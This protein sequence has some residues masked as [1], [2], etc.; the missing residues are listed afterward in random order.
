MF[1]TVRIITDSRQDALIIPKKA[2]LLETDEDDV[3]VV[4]DGRAERIRIELG[5]TDGDRVQVMSGLEV[6]DEVITVGQEGLKDNAPVR[7]VG[8]GE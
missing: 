1:A 2:L 7:I 6:G 5:Y 3:F 4:R 8:G